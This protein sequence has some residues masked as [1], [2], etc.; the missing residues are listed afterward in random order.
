MATTSNNTNNFLA[1]GSQ[2]TFAGSGVNTG[3]QLSALDPS[4]LRLSQAGASMGAYGIFANRS[5]SVFNINFQ[6]ADGTPIATERDWRLRVSMAPTTA[7]SFYDN[8][9]NPIMY[10][11]GSQTGTSGVIFPYT[12]TITVSHNARYN[13]TALTHSNYSSY[14]YEGSEVAA[15]SI[16]AEFTVQ[17]VPEG[18]YLMAVIHFFRACTKM[19]WG[20][21]PNA[22]SPPPL[23]Y[24]DGYGPTYLPHVPCVV[25]NFTHTMPAD[26]DYVQIPVGAPVNQLSPDMLY[27]VENLG[28]PV[29]LPTSS[30]VSLNLQPV[31]SRNNIARNFSLEKFAKG[32]LIQ[33]GTSPIGGFL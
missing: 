26:V 21:E 13:P 11:L 20:N 23:V 15:I 16:Q 7:R 1:D 29:R 25:T 12:P 30:T 28:G 18:Q 27:N 2:Q 17:N 10:P 24:L 4:A 33:N 5:G 32:D 31:Y 19:F 14:F 8:G 9:A 22:G 6:S 3:G